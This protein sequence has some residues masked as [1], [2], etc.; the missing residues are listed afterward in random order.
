MTT[1]FGDAVAGSICLDAELEALNH[2]HV[3]WEELTDAE[4][5]VTLGRLVDGLS[6]G[7]KLKIVIGEIPS[8]GRLW[9]TLVHHSCLKRLQSPTCERQQRAS[10]KIADYLSHIDQKYV[11]CAFME[12]LQFCCDHFDDNFDVLFQRVAAVVDFGC[13]LK[14]ETAQTIDITKSESFFKILRVQDTSS[15]ANVHRLAFRFAHFLSKLNSPNGQTFELP[16]PIND[17]LIA[18]LFDETA[19]P[20]TDGPVELKLTADE[21]VGFSL[22]EDELKQLAKH[23]RPETVVDYI[24]TWRSAEE[25]TAVLVAFYTFPDFA[26]RNQSAVRAQSNRLIDL[27]MNLENRFH[28]KNFAMEINS[29]LVAVLACDLSAVPAFCERLRTVYGPP[30]RSRII[31]VLKILTQHVVQKQR[32]P[33]FI[34]TSK[35]TGNKRNHEQ[36][37][38]GKVVRKSVALTGGA[39]NGT[40]AKP[41][42]DAIDL[43]LRPL[44]QTL[45][46]IDPNKIQEPMTSSAIL[47]LMRECHQLH[48]S[49]FRRV[50]GEYFTLLANIR[51]S[52]DYNIQLLCAEAYANLAQMAV[53][54]AKDSNAR[55]E[56]M[57]HFDGVDGWSE[58]LVQKSIVQSDRNVHEQLNNFNRGIRSLL[59]IA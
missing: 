42:V 19:G 35:S 22:P 17:D 12:T 10:W 26:E 44:L 24:H 3:N 57:S 36:K 4:L 34:P 51:E 5:K 15:D 58:K 31:K 46:S 59:S 18:C 1:N 53:Q 28:L 47:S 41:T 8:A 2:A 56:W 33:T 32:N 52:A 20:Q 13:H 49:G 30:D 23:Q 21:D 39:S 11:K 16:D 40:E 48:I 9:N 25:P 45:L 55:A 38:I 43:I 50:V 14:P 27:L 37:E 7:T 29:C 54:E 6:D